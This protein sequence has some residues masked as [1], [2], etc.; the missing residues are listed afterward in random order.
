MSAF[1]E[2]IVPGGVT[3]SLEA[4]VVRISKIQFTVHIEFK[5][6]MSYA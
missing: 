5:D 6:K 1:T 2:P 4:I 3:Y